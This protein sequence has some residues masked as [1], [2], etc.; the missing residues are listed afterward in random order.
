MSTEPE[1]THPAAPEGAGTEP[2][3]TETATPDEQPED[4][5]EDEAGDEDKAEEPAAPPLEPGLVGSQLTTATRA[6]TNEVVRELTRLAPRASRHAAGIAQKL[7]PFIAQALAEP[8]PARGRSLGLVAALGRA[9]VELARV[10]GV[11]EVGRKVEDRILGAILRGLARVLTLALAAM[12]VVGCAGPAAIDG[13]AIEPAVVAVGD[14]LER[15]IEADRAAP[16]ATQVAT[17]LERQLALETL[18]TLRTLIA[19]ATA[20]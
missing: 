14:M 6:A 4:E 19:E 12:L 9:E 10:R 5:L 16:P 3:S 7:A 13:A 17:E 1:A 15:Y 20:Q 8:E 18:N 2:E 11:R